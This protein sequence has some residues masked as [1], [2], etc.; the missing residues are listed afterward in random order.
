MPLH[1]P[2]VLGSRPPGAEEPGTGPS[3]YVRDHHAGE[4]LLFG[5]GALPGE[6]SILEGGPLFPFL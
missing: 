5:G 2:G 3:G 1:R 6:E 4:K